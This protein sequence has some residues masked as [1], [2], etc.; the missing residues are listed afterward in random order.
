MKIGAM[1]AILATAGTVTQAKD[2]CTN[3][4]PIV[5]V[6]L[7]FECGGMQVRQRAEGIASE[8]LGA[9]GVCVQWRTGWPK[10]NQEKHPI[11]IEITSDTPEV[12]CQGA[13]GCARAYEG[14][15]IKVFWDRIQKT[16]GREAAYALLAHVL[17]HEI[18]HILEGVDQHSPEGVMKAHWTADDVLQMASKSLSFD[19]LDVKL[20]HDG[21]KRF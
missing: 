9:A 8:I 17:A 10:T 19:P 18:T 5:T 1:M 12:V 2:D 16:S 20:I 13:L 11:L 15:H 21:L 6:Y 14:V 7:R 4:L 3:Q